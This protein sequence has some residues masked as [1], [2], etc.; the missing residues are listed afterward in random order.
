M[1]RPF[2]F[3]ILDRL[4]EQ[5][6][7]IV[8]TPAES[9]PKLRPCKKREMAQRGELVTDG[10]EYPAAPSEE[11]TTARAALLPSH[12]E[13]KTTAVADLMTVHNCSVL[14]IKPGALLF[15][16]LSLIYTKAGGSWKRALPPS[17]SQNLNLQRRRSE[18]PDNDRD[19]GGNKQHSAS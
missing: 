6:C 12:P 18:R 7:S 13:N 5:S 4:A 16:R 19:Q 17:S 10:Y 1:V 15:G 11:Q 2:A 3:P 8:T 9:L 14:E